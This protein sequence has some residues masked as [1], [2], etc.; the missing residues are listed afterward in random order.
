MPLFAI[1]GIVEVGGKALSTRHHHARP[2]LS[3]ERPVS[4]AAEGRRLHAVVRRSLPR[5]DAVLMGYSIT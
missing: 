1:T 5:L 4:A 2:H 3:A